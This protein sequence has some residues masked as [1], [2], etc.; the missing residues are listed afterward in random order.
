M[1]TEKKSEM[2]AL[3]DKQSTLTTAAATCCFRPTS[4]RKALRVS[5]AAFR[6]FTR[7]YFAQTGARTFEE[8]DR[9]QTAAPLEKTDG[10]TDRPTDKQTGTHTYHLDVL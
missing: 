8:T 3:K 7:Y 4:G 6:I 5:K 10:Q 1:R 2:K 9:E